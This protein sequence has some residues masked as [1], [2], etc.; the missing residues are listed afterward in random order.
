MTIDQKFVVFVL[1]IV[2]V[3]SLLRF[4]PFF[5]A[6]ERYPLHAHN[7]MAPTFWGRFLGVIQPVT[8]CLFCRAFTVVRRLLACPRPNF[9][10]C[11]KTSLLFLRANSREPL[12]PRTSEQT[13]YWWRVTQ[14]PP[15]SMTPLFVNGKLREPYL[16][17]RYFAPQIP[18]EP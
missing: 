17:G 16:G 18:R 12:L 3:S 1:K 10:S 9:L 5:D 14:K 6:E 15:P 8:V 4:S 7:L 11:G 2:S 13:I